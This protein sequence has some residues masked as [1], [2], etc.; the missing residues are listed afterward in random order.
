MGK[1][2]EQ[3]FFLRQS[4]PLALVQLLIATGL[5]KEVL[6][7]SL[8]RVS[9]LLIGMLPIGQEL[10]VQLPEALIEAVQELA[11]DRDVGGQLLVMAK[12]MN[13]TESSFKRQ[14]VTLWRI[15]TDEQFYHWPQCLGSVG[16][17]G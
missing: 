2:H 1:H 13:P 3:R 6:E 5:P 16:G 8:Q 15:V 12:F 17:Y 11:M 9:V 4:Q 10:A 14:P 7:L